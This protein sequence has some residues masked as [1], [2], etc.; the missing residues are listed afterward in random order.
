MLE[1]VFFVKFRGT[2]LSHLPATSG[3]LTPTTNV[4]MLSVSYAPCWLK[5][6]CITGVGSIPK[7]KVT[8]SHEI[9]FPICISHDSSK[10]TPRPLICK[11]APF[12]LRRFDLRLFRIL[13]MTRAQLSI[14]TNESRSY[15]FVCRSDF[16]LKFQR[17]F[18]SYQLSSEWR[19]NKHYLPL[20]STK[21]LMLAFKPAGTKY[22]YI[23]DYKIYMWRYTK[24]W[25]RLTEWLFVR[26]LV[27]V[28]R[29]RDSS[30][31]NYTD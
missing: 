30:R 31:E 18:F 21:V 12:D 17:F 16:S 5:L 3:K 14:A 6:S 23:I 15:H 24:L 25:S 8:Y 11:V 1:E 22:R 20:S 2:C 29:G 9:L 26:L 7:S 19:L 28:F 10:A 27:T 4:I 13:Q